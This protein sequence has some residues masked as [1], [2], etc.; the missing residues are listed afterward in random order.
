MAMNEN[1]STRS[2]RGC[3]GRRTSCGCG[4]GCG[5]FLLVLLV[6]GALSLFNLV[7]GIGFSVHIPF[8]S[9]NFTAAGTIGTKAEAVETL[10]DYVEPMLAGNENF[11]NHSTTM[12]IGPA[13][14]IGILVIGEQPGA[15]PIDLYLALR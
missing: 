1:D 7:F 5:T 13:E 8:T 15:P 10:P 2:Y 9:S 11:I 4:S 12:T 3:S 6:G 14:G